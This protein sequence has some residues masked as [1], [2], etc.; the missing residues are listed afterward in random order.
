MDSLSVTNISWHPAKKFL[1]RFFFTYFLIYC[2]PFPIDAFEFTKPVV[3]PFY[4]FLDWLIPY[5]AD[6][7]FHLHAILSFPMFDKMDDSNYGLAFIYFNIIISS[8]VAITWSLLD[9][10]TTNYEKLYQWLRFYLRYYLAAFLFGYG[11]IK[12]FPSQFQAI[13]AS[14]LTMQVGEQSAML[15]AWNFMGYSTVLMRLNGIVE[16]LAG[17]LLLFR[18][19][20]T[21]GAIL[22][23]CAFG[24][25]AVMDFCF[26]VPVRLLASHLLIM[27]VFL[28]LED[29]WKLLNIFL[30]NKPTVSTISVPLINHRKWQKFFL[31]LQ[32]LFIVA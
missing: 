1:F 3:Q 16:V 32:A 24:F 6:K 26:N 17:L 21:I 4:K 13:T 29:R 2:F 18:R 10:R 27:S 14:R 31:A 20:T 7:W 23:S 25:I 5:I 30:L 19:T 8:V 22:A 15:L 11:F 28:I 9:R 12:V